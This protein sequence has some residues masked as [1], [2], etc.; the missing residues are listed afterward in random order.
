MP[1]A[2]FDLTIFISLSLSIRHVLNYY[3]WQHEVRRQ[4]N[5]HENAVQEEIHVKGGGMG[6]TPPD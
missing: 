5:A 3:T 1:Q 6:M 4:N 2:E